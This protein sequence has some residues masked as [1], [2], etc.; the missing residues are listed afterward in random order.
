MPTDITGERFFLNLSFSDYPGQHVVNIATTSLKLI[1]TMKQGYA[2]R[3]DIGYK[4]I[5]KVSDTFCSYFNVQLFTRLEKSLT[6]E[7]TYELLDPKLRL[8]D[9]EYPTY[10]P[11]SICSLIQSEYGDCV[12]RNIWTAVSHFLT[13]SP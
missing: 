11:A 6:L 10:G 4:L 2:P 12:I 3:V 13:S 5:L 8:Q 9:S 7:Q 1:K